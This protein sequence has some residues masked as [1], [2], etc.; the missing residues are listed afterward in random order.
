[1]TT[2]LGSLNRG[3]SVC[4]GSVP[5]MATLPHELEPVAPS[6]RH[7][8]MLPEFSSIVVATTAVFEASNCAHAGSLGCV[9]LSSI[10][11]HTGSDGMDDP[12]GI[13]II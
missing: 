13:V 3:E 9:P 1:M 4:P 8:H 7:I 2:G 12:S 5:A 10:T 11:S 6:R